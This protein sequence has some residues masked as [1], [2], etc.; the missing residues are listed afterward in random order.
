MPKNHTK[1]VMCLKTKHITV[2]VYWGQNK[3]YL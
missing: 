1:T 2:F 3:R